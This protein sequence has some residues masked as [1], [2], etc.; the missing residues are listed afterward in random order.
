VFSLERGLLIV[1]ASLPWLLGLAHLWLLLLL[2]ALLCAYP[3]L[4]RLLLQTATLHCRLALTLESFPRQIQTDSGCR[5]LQTVGN[6]TILILVFMV[7]K[8]ARNN[9]PVTLV[10]IISNRFSKPIKTRHPNPCR[11]HHFPLTSSLVLP[12]IRVSNTER[13]HSLPRLRKPQLG[14]TPKVAPE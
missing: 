13:T 6:L 1:N 5:Y 11:V 8:P 7:H 14:I 2:V 4:L 10:Q 3:T 9:N 12:R